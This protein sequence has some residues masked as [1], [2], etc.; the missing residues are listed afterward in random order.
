MAPSTS[1]APL[2][3]LDNAFWRFAPLN[4]RIGDLFVERGRVVFVSYRAFQHSGSLGGLAF[5]GI[6]SPYS[7][8]TSAS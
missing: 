6:S 7:R 4:V 3:V 8:A 2:H 5:S 1:E